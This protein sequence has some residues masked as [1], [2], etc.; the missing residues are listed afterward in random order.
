MHGNA[1]ADSMQCCHRARQGRVRQPLGEGAAHEGYGYTLG[2]MRRGVSDLSARSTSTSAA[3]ME[4][5]KQST[6]I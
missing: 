5:I 2:H 3:R 6:A 4:S 1:N